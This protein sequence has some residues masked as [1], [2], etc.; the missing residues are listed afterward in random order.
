MLKE[1]YKAIASREAKEGDVLIDVTLSSG[2]KVLAPSAEL[3]D[4]FKN[5][6]HNLKEKCFLG[7]VAA[8]NRA[9]EVADYE[10]RFRKQIENNGEAL[11]RLREIVE[12]SRQKNVWLVC[13]EG[14]KKKCHRHILLEICKERFG[15]EVEG[16]DF[17]GVFS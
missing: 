7:D 15:A 14:R 10:K 5:A 17:D 6:E 9:F 13:F 1:T 16:D 12:L 11:A 4:D 8:H 3:L 2:E